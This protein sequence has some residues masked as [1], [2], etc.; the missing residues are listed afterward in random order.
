VLTGP[1][2]LGF[3]I[4]YFALAARWSLGSEKM[5]PKTCS[6][7]D[8][9]YWKVEHY[10]KRN[11]SPLK[12][13]FA[14]TPFRN[15]ISRLVGI[16]V[17]AKVFDDGSFA[18]EK[19]LVEIGDYC[20]LNAMSVLQCHSLEDAMFKSDRIKLGKG[21]SIGPNAFVHYGVTI[22]DNAVVDPDS[23]VMKGETVGADTTWR[24]N[25]ARQI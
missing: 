4:G 21:C 9:H 7:Y 15:V 25:P 23:F 2:L 6:I 19:L 3:T 8:P 18:S 20:T 5:T 24:G 16:K 22:G 14:G 11:E 13:V 10:W 17:G 1:C 12:N